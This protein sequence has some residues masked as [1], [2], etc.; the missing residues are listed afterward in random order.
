MPG[1]GLE[2][3]WACGPKDFK[4]SASAIPPPRLQQEAWAGIEPAYGGFADRCVTT[5]P[6]GPLQGSVAQKPLAR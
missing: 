6:P 5:S 2:P 1:A 3:A 4:S